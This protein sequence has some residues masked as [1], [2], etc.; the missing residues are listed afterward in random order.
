MPAPF[1][2]DL[3]QRILDAL[4]QGDASMRAIAHRFDVSHDTV[5]R[6]RRRHVRGQ[7]LAPRPI[8]GASPRIPEHHHSLFHAWIAHDPT[9]SQHELAARYAEAT[10]VAVSDRTAGRLRAKLGYTLKKRR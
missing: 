6:L 9:L 4:L 8:P 1:S 3:R 5:E 2:P 7:G 10:G